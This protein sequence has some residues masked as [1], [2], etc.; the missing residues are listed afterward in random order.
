MKSLFSRN[1]AFTQPSSQHL[2]IVQT[3]KD[4]SSYEQKWP[5]W[6]Y[7]KT[8]V[9]RTGIWQIMSQRQVLLMIIM[10]IWKNEP[11]PLW[12][13]EF[14][15]IYEQNWKERIFLKALVDCLWSNSIVMPIRISSLL[16]K[17]Q[18]SMKKSLSW[19]FDLGW[20]VDKLR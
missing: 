5:L 3:K 2:E 12:P 15:A 18:I 14:L 20:H 16:F 6:F 8:C 17:S 1:K 7:D 19:L 10:H 4:H 13:T 11:S 9:F